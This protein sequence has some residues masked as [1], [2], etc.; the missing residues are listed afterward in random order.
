MSAEHPETEPKALGCCQDGKEPCTAEPKI[1]ISVMDSFL[2]LLN[3]SNGF[4][5]TEQTFIEALLCE[6]PCQTL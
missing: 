3:T 6:T 2:S 1:K 5:S 4:I